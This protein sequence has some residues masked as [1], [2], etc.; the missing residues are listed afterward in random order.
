[1]TIYNEI[2]PECSMITRLQD[3][4]ASLKHTMHYANTTGGRDCE[5]MSRITYKDVVYANNSRSTDH[6]HDPHISLRKEL[7]RHDPL[8][9]VPW[10]LSRICHR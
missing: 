4:Q 6:R 10:I 5:H 2:L 7:N 3:T 8:P 1:M 9:T